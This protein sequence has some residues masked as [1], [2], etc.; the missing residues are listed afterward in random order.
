MSGK[1]VL[2]RGLYEL[3]SGSPQ[4]TTCEAVFG[5]DQSQQSRAFKFFINHIYDN[6]LF[7]VT[8]NLQWWNDKGFFAESNAAIKAKLEELGLDFDDVNQ[9]DVGFFLDCNCMESSRVAGGPRE[10]GPDAERWV[11]IIQRAFYNG[12]K[13]IHGLKHQTLDLAHGFTIDMFGPTSLR[14]SDLHL[15]AESN[16]NTRLAEVQEGSAKQLKG[17]GDSIYPNDSH[18]DSYHKG[19]DLTVRQ[20]R[21][22]GKMK[23]VRIAIEW[24]YGVTANL[25]RYLKNIQKL[26]VMNGATVAK[27]YTVATILRNCH[28]ALY[29][30]ISSSYFN[31]RIPD[32]MLEQYLQL[33]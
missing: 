22:N 3:V 29:G 14:R 21:E 2:L 19:T 17:F 12:W 20:R 6:F 26:K 9:C 8:D 13:S 5:R 27:V 15:L 4:F 23:R 25:F 24:N 11:D 7:L 33:I 10:D 1:E 16:I 28:V 18:V 32:D 30:G 31:I